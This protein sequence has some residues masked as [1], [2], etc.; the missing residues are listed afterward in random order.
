YCRRSLEIADAGGLEEYGAFAQCS[1][2]HVSVVAGDL[3]GA[4]VAGNRALPS[5]ERQG[6]LWWA[7]RTLWG[8]SI[9]FN[10]IGD[11]TRSLECCR[12]GRAY[13]EKLSDLRLK[14]VGSFRTGSTHILRGDPETGLRYCDE[15]LALSSPVP[16]DTAMTKAVRAL[17]LVKAGDAATGTAELREAVAWFER[18][19]LRY[20]RSVVALWLAEARLRQGEPAEARALIDEVLAAT[21]DV[22]YRQLEGVALRL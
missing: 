3:R 17:G 19:K 21:R 18:S 4:V 10:A 9:A 8:L 7:C 22:G 1:L 11:W 15:A 5:F 14:V 20:T 12:Q 16:F 2:T 6:N 13:G